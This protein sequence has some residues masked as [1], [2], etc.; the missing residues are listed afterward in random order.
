[1]TLLCFLLLLAS[2]E[3]ERLLLGKSPFFRIEGMERARRAG[4]VALLQRA[5][6]SNHW[7]ARRAAALALGS[8]TPVAL[9]KD[10]VAVVRAA[11]I[12]ALDTTAPEDALWLRTRDPDS[13]VRAAAAWALRDA[14]RK[15]NLKRLLDDPVLD[16]R[17]A[18]MAAMG[19]RRELLRLARDKDLGTALGALAALGRCGDASAAGT[20]LRD[21]GKSIKSSSRKRMVFVDST[22]TADYARARAVGEMARRDVSV[23]GR[24]VARRLRK[25]VDGANLQGR[26]GIVLSEAVAAGRDAE[27]ARRIV[28]AQV[29]ARKQS[30]L[31]F[32]AINFVLRGG[33]H[34]F[35]REPW[36]E[37]APLLLPLLADRDVHVRRAV[38][39]ALHGDAARLALGDRD[40][41]VRAIGCA[42]IG[43]QAPLLAA[44]RDPEPSV[45][46][47]AI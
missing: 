5:A 12:E 41:P 15:S 36:P 40:A 42:R 30:T 26:A 34:A 46:V 4:D 7:D 39:E 19:R 29:R 32:H 21:L 20:L 44:L 14:S 28:D 24:S 25:L 8:G 18:A 27:A 13:A 10:P 47:A 9:L 1:M 45:R 31:P 38:A 2:P 11:A 37:L 43:K 17:L 33:M 6:R 35:A 16:V 22:A 23:G 3:N